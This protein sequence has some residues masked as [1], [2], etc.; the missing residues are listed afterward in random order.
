M[1]LVTEPPEPVPLADVEGAC[2]YLWPL[3]WALL[4][5]GVALGLFSANWSSPRPAIAARPSHDA[6]LLTGSADPGAKA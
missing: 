1:G 5:H 2:V 6:D 4:F 3:A